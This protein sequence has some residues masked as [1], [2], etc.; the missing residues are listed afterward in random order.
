M[1]APILRALKAVQAKN[2]METLN[3]EIPYWENE[4]YWIRINDKEKMTVIFSIH[5]VDE[6]DR[7]L[8]KEIL[9]QLA[10]A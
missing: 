6:V 3:C 1:G 5:Y 10:E 8:A 4:K 9:T 2:A 7:T